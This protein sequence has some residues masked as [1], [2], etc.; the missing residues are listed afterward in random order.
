MG[1]EQLKILQEAFRLFKI[2]AEKGYYKSM[3]ELGKMYLYGDGVTQNHNKA[4]K[5]FLRAAEE[6]NSTAMYKIGK[7]YLYGDGIA[8]D[9]NKAVEMVNKK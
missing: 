4:L 5:W 9:Y 1:E 3:Y 6:G 2:T 7:M 8:Q